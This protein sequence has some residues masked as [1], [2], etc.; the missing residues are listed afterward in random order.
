MPFHK[1][2]LNFLHCNVFA[3][4]KLVA[5]T[6][7]VTYV[8]VILMTDLCHYHIY[9]G[10]SSPC[11]IHALNFHCEINKNKLLIISHISF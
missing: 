10:N 5:M 2:I 9:S 1:Y 8:C 4:K 11:I 6:F 3:Q 7:E